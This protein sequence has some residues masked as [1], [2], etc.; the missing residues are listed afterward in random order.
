MALPEVRRANGRALWAAD[1]HVDNVEAALKEAV[2][3]GASGTGHP[4]HVGL[5]SPGGLPFCVVRDG[6]EF[7][8]R[9]GRP[10]NS[11]TKVISVPRRAG[12]HS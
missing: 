6:G 2:Q 8:Y 1:L 4:A 9:G 10:S 11:L 3:L 7:I 12:G 5:T